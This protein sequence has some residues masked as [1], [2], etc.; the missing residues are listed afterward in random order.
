MIF[1]YSVVSGFKAVLGSVGV[2]GAMLLIVMIFIRT[3]DTPYDDD[4]VSD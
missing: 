2:Q 3:T 4:T 1:N